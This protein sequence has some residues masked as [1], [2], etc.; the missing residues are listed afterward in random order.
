[1]TM[2]DVP[3]GE[4]LAVQIA[5]GAGEPERLLLLE[6]PSLGCVRLL[7]WSSADWSRLPLRRERPVGELLEELRRADAARRLVG[8]ELY[9]VERWLGDA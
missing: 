9:R 6:R 5:G 3:A 1:M 2:P 7:E 8:V 4:T